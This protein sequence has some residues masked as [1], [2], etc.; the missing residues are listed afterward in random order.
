M[1]NSATKESGTRPSRSRANSL[2][3]AAAPDNTTS[4]QPPPQGQT[5]RFVQGLY[6][7]RGARGS[8]PDLSFLHIGSNSDRDPAQSEQRRE[9]KQEREARKLE[10]ARLAREQAREKSL[11]E[12]SVD[13]GF[14]VTLGV[15]TGV[16][17]F[18]KPVVRQLQVSCAARI[19][20]P[21]T[22][23]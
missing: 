17:D 11:Q 20:A 2:P 15:Y 5:D 6:A 21:G 18:N 22:A 1:G 8:R 12:E 19:E 9:T 14:L 16:E 23:Y 13:G 10:K 3:T 7:T 4:P